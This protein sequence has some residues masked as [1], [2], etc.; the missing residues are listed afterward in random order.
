MVVHS[1]RSRASTETRY[2]MPSVSV[3]IPSVRGGP[4]LREAIASV[5]AQTM[6]DWEVI[7]VLDGC[8]DDLS[9][10]ERSDSRIKSIRQENRGISRSRN[11]GVGLANAE[12]IAFLDDDDRMLPNRLAAQCSVMSDQNVGLC[13]TQFQLIDEAGSAIATGSAKDSQYI[14]FLRNEGAIL[15]SSTMLRKGLFREV[16]GFNP[17][18]P[19]NEDLDLIYRIARESPLAFL[20][21]V[22]TEY[23]RHDSN[24]WRDFFEQGTERKLILRKHLLAAEAQMETEHVEAI[25]YGLRHVTTGRTAKA[26]RYAHEAR[27]RG[28]YPGVLIALAFAFVISPRLTI[29][30]SMN[31]VRRNG[32]HLKP[33]TSPETRNVDREFSR[34]VAI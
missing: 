14:D 21:E 8:D 23:R 13:H 26:I 30:L 1:G 12:L 9:E 31:E 24:I 18:L 29:A 3:V 25:H 7:V 10:V 5:Q 16:G 32:L 28:N 19:Q 4:F 2:L 20:P 22:L 17:L 27:T 34:D 15:I 33:R 11:I 6:S